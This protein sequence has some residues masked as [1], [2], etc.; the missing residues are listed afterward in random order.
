MGMFLISFVAGVVGAIAFGYWQRA[1]FVL[2][3]A[4]CC[5][6]ASLLIV[7][8]L[9]LRKH[10]QPRNMHNDDASSVADDSEGPSA[11][12]RFWAGYYSVNR[13]ILI[14]TYTFL[15]PILFFFT[16]QLEVKMFGLVLGLYTLFG[17]LAARVSLRITRSNESKAAFY[18]TAF[19]TVIG[20]LLLI[21]GVFWLAVIAV[22]LL[23]LAGGFVRPTTM[24][25]LGP[26]MEG[27]SASARQ[28]LMRGL[29]RKQ[30][31]I[32]V[33]LL[34]AF[35]I[36]ASLVTSFG[37]VF[38]ALAVLAAMYSLIAASLERMRLQHKSQAG[39]S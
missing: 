13:G 37:G 25:Y 32:Q 35:G 31:L 38:L 8:G 17:L 23:G 6:A 14:S 21:P 1:P 4:S 7:R 10:L 33:V 20:L 36:W 26:E 5:V 24:I 27:M 12:A 3:A 34:V 22:A 29:E 2:S 28:R 19:A 15:L 9:P 30:G 11:H 16:L 39:P 18:V